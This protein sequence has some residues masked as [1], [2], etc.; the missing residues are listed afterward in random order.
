MIIDLF[1]Y[2][3]KNLLKRDFMLADPIEMN[4]IEIKLY[5]LLKFT[6]DTSMALCLANSLIYWKEFVPYDQMV[7]YKWWYRHGYMSSTGHCFD[8]GAATKKSVQ[9]FEKRQRKFAEEHGLSLKDMDFYLNEDRSDGFDINCSEEGVAGNGALMRLAPVPLFFFRNP[10]K[11]VQYSGESGQITHGDKRAID[12]CRYYGA[13]IVA[14]LQGREKDHLLSDTFVHEHKDWFGTEPLH[15]DIMNISRGSFKKTGG[16]NDGIRGKGFIVNALEAALWAFWNDQNSIEKGLLDAVNLG[17]DTDTTAAIYGQLAGAS[18]GYDSLPNKWTDVV[19]AKDFLL[20]LT[21]WI[22]YEGYQWFERDSQLNSSNTLI[23]SNPQRTSIDDLRRKTS[24]FSQIRRSYSIESYS[25]NI[26]IRKSV[27]NSIKIGSV[28]NGYTDSFIGSSIMNCDMKMIESDP[29]ERYEYFKGDDFEYEK[30]FHY[31]NIDDEFQLSL[32]TNLTHSNQILSFIN[33]PF[34]IDQFTRIILYSKSIKKS[35][36]SLHSLDQHLKFNEDSTHILADIDWG[37]EILIFIRL[38]SDQLEGFDHLRDRIKDC[39]I[40]N[41]SIHFN[42]T[43]QINVYS[44]IHQLNKQTNL[45]EI[46]KQINQIRTNPSTYQSINHYLYPIKHFIGTFSS[47]YPIKQSIKQKILQYFNQHQWINKYWTTK[48]S[49]DKHF[50]DKYLYE[51]Y[52]ELNNRL[53]QFNENIQTEKYQLKELIIQCRK[54]KYFNDQLENSVKVILSKSNFEDLNSLLT[55]Y[56]AKISFIN[57]LLNRGIDY[58]NATIYQIKQN[59]QLSSIESE[60]VEKNPKCYLI[61]SNDNLNYSNWNKLSNLFQLILKEQNKR[62]VYI[63]FTYSSLDLNEISIIPSLNINWNILSDQSSI[64]FIDQNNPSIA[65][66]EK[67]INILLLGKSNIGKST[68]INNLININQLNSFDDLYSKDLSL[69]IPISCPTD[70]HFSDGHLIEIGPIDSN[71]VSYSFNGSKTQLNKSHLIKLNNE[72]EISLID[73]FQLESNHLKYFL[74]NLIYS[75]QNLNYLNGICFLIQSNDDEIN[76]YQKSIEILLKYFGQNLFPNLYFC[77]TKIL[78]FNSNENELMNLINQILLPFNQ[79]FDSKRIYR[80]DNTF[81]F[82]S[83]IS[84][85]KDF[86]KSKQ[87]FHLSKEELNRFLNNIIASPTIDLSLSNSLLYSIEIKQ[88]IRPLFETLRNCLRNQILI[89]RN[90]INSLIQINPISM[91]YIS[92]KCYS[93]KS[94][95]TKYG[96]FYIVL[97][98]IHHLTYQCLQCLCHSNDHFIIDYQLNYSYSNNNE[99]TFDRQA[100]LYTILTLIKHFSNYLREKEE[101]DH[102]LNYLNQMIDDERLICHS[103]SNQFNFILYNQLQFIKKDYQK[104]IEQTPIQISSLI[105]CA[106]QIPLVSI[107]LN[108]TTK[109][110]H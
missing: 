85:E 24:S 40:N 96:L 2:N 106:K 25:N 49:I 11:A 31:L 28:Y 69:R 81:L 41:Q 109:F 19:Y 93:C 104:S 9:E 100:S 22:E 44:N 54:N 68:L 17:D 48:S 73:T 29:I 55:N 101:T 7:R 67:R 39:L 45:N 27:E 46:L 95:L 36:D 60:L 35:I 23:N 26:I 50:I 79:K 63:D 98:H 13:L 65:K 99:Q 62:F 108:A 15:E 42:E 91:K 32:L 57:D 102:F 4:L 64:E 89:E 61:C 6:D 66:N 58:Q 33:Y 43:Y 88:L 12:A 105:R 70:K 71:E 97:D 52:K 34:L 76:L 1:R 77:F 75:I 80:I 8:I 87:S 90:Q 16:Y 30:L 10:I 94:Y 37:I 74:E 56:F 53:N 82:K 47:F 83:F 103:K 18:Y 38:P 21:H 78:S 5:Y 3:W 59:D 14:A 107:Q 110:I 86:D 84:L 72:I 51:L 92:S 20:C